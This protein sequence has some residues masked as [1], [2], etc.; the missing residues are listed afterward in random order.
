MEAVV[1]VVVITVIAAAV[2]VTLLRIVWKA[3]D[4]VF[5]W[6]IYTFGNEPARRE[7]ARRMAQRQ[8]EEAVQ[9]D[10]CGG[11][12]LAIAFAIVVLIAGFVG[13]FLGAVWNSP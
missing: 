9:P 7:A 3:V 13:W 5:N 8:V 10:G 12:A 1:V 6:L 2:G 11:A 4:N